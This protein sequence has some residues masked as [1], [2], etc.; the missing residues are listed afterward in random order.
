MPLGI[1]SGCH[2][3][4]AIFGFLFDKEKFMGKREGQWK[5][6]NLFYNN[7]TAYGGMFGSAQGLIKYEQ[8]LLQA[9]S[10]LLDDKYK[11]ILFTESFKQNKPT[12]MS[13]SWFTGS[14]KGNR[15]YA[16]AGGGG[17]YYIELRVYPE[18]G[19][20]STIMYNRSGMTD[21]RILDQADGFF[22]AEKI[23]DSNLSAKR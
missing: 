21:V 10:V 6:F 23:H 20:G 4:M 7:G 12:G 16:H 17:G 13:L 2:L 8:T 1:I 9:N 11:Q 18:L 5:P 19:V 15:Y 22:I 14:L 3:P